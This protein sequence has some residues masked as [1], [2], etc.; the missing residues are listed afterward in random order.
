MIVV[1][2]S[3]A[4]KW[5]L[6]EPGDAA[7]Q[8]LLT[9]GDSLL[10]P[11]LIRVEVAAAIARKARVGEIDAQDAETAA[12]LWLQAIADGVVT[13]VLDERDLPRALRLAIALNHPLQDCLYLALAER[14]GAA[15]ITAD[16]RFVTKAGPSHP[17]VRLLS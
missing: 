9:G 7:A 13:L 5:L 4:V 3:V 2:A 17:E 10:G 14:L 1:D 11:E 8:R 15:L 16:E 12:E 6:P